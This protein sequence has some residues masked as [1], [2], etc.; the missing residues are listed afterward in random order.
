MPLCHFKNRF[1]LFLASALFILGC[2]HQPYT[3]TPQS[4]LNFIEN[5]SV[6]GAIFPIKKGGSEGQIRIYSPGIVKVK[7]DSKFKNQPA[8]LVRIAVSNFGKEKWKIDVREQR[9]ADGGNRIPISV[10]T[11]H[12]QPPFS[13]VL[14]KKT[15]VLDLYFAPGGHKDDQDLSEFRFQWMVHTPDGVVGNKLTLL[16]H[17]KEERAI[18]PSNEPMFY[19]PIYPWGPF[20]W[21]EPGYD[22]WLPFY[23]WGP[24]YL[25]P[26]Y[27]QPME[28]PADRAEHPCTPDYPCSDYYQSR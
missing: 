26:P 14:P 12:A 7:G 11:D 23:P 25:S 4:G 6:K 16:R 15:Q 3:Y 18:S 17:Q 2:A 20:W 1:P 5:N 10:N 8:I 21:D 24:N 9:L 22:P 28:P 19:D 13:E 27:Y